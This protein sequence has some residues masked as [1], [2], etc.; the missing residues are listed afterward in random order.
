M[1]FAQRAL[2]WWIPLLYLL[3]ADSFYL[4]TYDSAQV[5]IT[6]VQMGGVTMLALWLCRL[7]DE[8]RSVFS[9]T[10]LMTLAPFLAYFAYGIFS[11]LHAPYKFSSTD[12]FLRRIF[13][14]TIPLIVI[15]EFN[16]A[17][18]GRFTRI[19]VWAT[20]ITVGYGVLQWFDIAFFPPGVGKGPDPFIW[21]QA[22]GLRVFST[23]GNPNFFANFLVLIL[24]V[25]ICQFMKTRRIGFLVLIAMLLLDLVAAKTK[26]AWVAFVILTAL[27]M[28]TYVYFFNWDLFRRYW[29]HMVLTL[30]LLSVGVLSAIVYMLG[31]SN[32]TSVNF[33]LFTWEATWEMV[34]TQPLVGTGIG[35][36]W[37]IY[38]AFRRPPIFHIEG[39]HNTETDHAENEHLEVLYDEGILGFGI[40]LWLIIATFTIAYRALGQLTGSL[41]KG[42]RAPPRAYDLLGYLIAF[43]GMLAHNFFDVSMRFVSSGVYLGLLSGL[44]I[45]LSRGKSL[46]E[47]HKSP[48][49]LIAEPESLWTS[50]AR[51]WAVLSGFLIWPARLL[52]WG[53]LGYI[54][55][56]LVLHQGGGDIP[57][58]G[59]V[60]LQGPA[61]R[62]QMGGDLLQWIIAWACFLFCVLSQGFIFAR[63]T[64]L[65]RNALVPLVI[66]LMIFPLKLTWG[67]FRADVHHNI[68]I[69]FS[70]RQNWEMALKNYLIVRSLN[71]AFVMASYFRGN[72]FND[73]FNMKEVYNPKWGDLMDESGHPIPRTDFQRALAAYAEVRA[74]APNYVQMHHQMGVLHLKRAQWE[75][76]EA[77]KA[78][79]KGDREKAARHAKAGEE[80]L[81]KAMDYFRLYQKHDPVFSANY[82]RMGQVYMMRGQHDKAIKA[83]QDLVYAPKCAVQPGWAKSRWMRK[84]LLAYQKYYDIEKDG[85]WKH[86][87]CRWQFNEAYTHLANA[88]LMA[89]RLVEAEKAY[90]TALH[91]NPK[92][93]HAKNNLRVLYQ[94]AQAAGRLKV[95]PPPPGQKGPPKLEVLPPK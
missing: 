30:T 29:K 2:V 63:V 41:K 39:K 84:T 51:G 83:Y 54:M 19:L 60:A 17:A 80:F 77:K 27:F 35:S 52:A 65:S 53:G 76:G 56:R 61:S 15:R 81:D 18:V 79:D 68:A 89:N 55:Y 28:G 90:K 92:S 20:W 21:R 26:G 94:K 25:L 49:G 82:Y 93:D 9:K 5:K 59:F 57:G 66:F 23:F 37:V 1:P 88:Y 13:Y 6:L 38:P 62:I 71:P 91:F 7:L 45:N 86:V 8:T 58:E 24:P 74:R 47:L 78:G 32:W 22:F 73:R 36:F 4:R 85:D 44:I 42:Q 10:D 72:V 46:S 87:H 34:M 64:L 16:E 67:F 31:H 69:F 12:A 95:T 11:Y 3:I 50:I 40:Y 43:Q 14:M 75:K 48:A 70:K 33:R